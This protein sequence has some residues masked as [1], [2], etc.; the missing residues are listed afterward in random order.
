M[1]NSIFCNNTQFFVL[2]SKVFIEIGN[3]L[4]AKINRFIIISHMYPR[5]MIIIDF[6]I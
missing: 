2:W 6:M 3:Y 5:S 4:T 1:E